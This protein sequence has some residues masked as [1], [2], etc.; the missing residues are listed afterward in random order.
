MSF[1]DEIMKKSSV[2]QEEKVDWDRIYELLDIFENA[3]DYDYLMS[4]E[5]INNM[6][7]QYK[8]RKN[9]KGYDEFITFCESERRKILYSRIVEDEYIIEA[10]NNNW[11]DIISYASIGFNWLLGDEACT[12]KRSA[13][14][15]HLLEVEHEYGDYV[16]CYELIKYMHDNFNNDKEYTLP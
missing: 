2:L 3:S 6:C 14:I 10:I 8:I 4:D 13:I 7:K 9:S 12:D 1:V 11:N 15:M 16:L 5:Y